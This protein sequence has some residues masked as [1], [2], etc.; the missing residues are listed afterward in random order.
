MPALKIWDD[1]LSEWVYLQMGGVQG[2]T[3][4]DGDTGVTGADG[5]TGNGAASNVTVSGAAEIVSATTA[6]TAAKT[7]ITSRDWAALIISFKL[8]AEQAG[9]GLT[10][11]WESG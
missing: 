2:D 8:A 3:G 10:I 6:Q 7:G 5:D 4:A 11:L 1:N 9:A